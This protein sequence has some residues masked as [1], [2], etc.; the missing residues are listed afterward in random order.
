MSLARAS[1]TR[2]LG[3][4]S[5]SPLT[6]VTWA[7]PEPEPS[8]EPKAF[9]SGVLVGIALALAGLAAVAMF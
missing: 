7:K 8:A 3:L 4:A 2:T 1:G 6:L 9:A 5:G